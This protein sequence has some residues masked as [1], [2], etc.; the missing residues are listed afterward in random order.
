MWEM[1]LNSGRKFRMPIKQPVELK[2]IQVSYKT[3]DKKIGVSRI[4]TLFK[5]LKLN[6]MIYE[7][8]VTGEE[9]GVSGLRDGELQYLEGLVK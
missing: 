3:I 6:G 8:N 4:K 2:E 7:E 5:M 1:C 9:L